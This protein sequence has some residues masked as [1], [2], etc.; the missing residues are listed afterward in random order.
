MSTTSPSTGETKLINT[1][2]PGDYYAIYTK[3]SDSSKT[4]PFADAGL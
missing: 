3:T 2:F 1:Y 4:S